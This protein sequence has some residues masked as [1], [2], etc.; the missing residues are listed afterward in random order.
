MVQRLLPQLTQPL[1]SLASVAL[2]EGHRVGLETVE[3]TFQTKKIMPPTIAMTIAKTISWP[4][5]HTDDSRPLLPSHSLGSERH[6]S[7]CVVQEPFGY[8]AARFFE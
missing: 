4:G 8:S 1:A 3:R 2:H 7:R 6:F 5:V